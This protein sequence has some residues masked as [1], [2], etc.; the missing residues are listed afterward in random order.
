MRGNDM[1]YAMEITLEEAFKGIE[2]TITVPINDT[3]NKC[4]GTGAGAGKAAETCSTCNGAGRVRAQQGFFTIERTCS[5]CGGEGEIIK[6]PCKACSGAGR[7]RREKSLKVNIPKGIDSGRRIRLSG[8]G[9]AGVKGGPAGDL[10]I[11]ISV[12][13][14]KFFKRDGANLYCRVPI[15]M[16]KATLGGDIEVPTISGNRSK[17][18]VPGGTQTGQ[19][20][21]LKEKGMPVIQSASVG[22]MY[23]EIFV[24]TP[25]NLNSKQKEAFK[26]L[27]K[28][29]SG[30]DGKKYSPESSGFVNRMK[31][32][33]TDLTE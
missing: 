14:H 26:S 11:L 22:D 21:R 8:E 15:A 30:K 32:L 9:E 31:D 2:Q 12:K 20:F 25:V 19:Q 10:Y 16:T 18:K 24:E 17:V 28:E 7:V 6:D 1:Q 23:I 5:T 27:D 29:L 4:E 13:P 33:W 3:C